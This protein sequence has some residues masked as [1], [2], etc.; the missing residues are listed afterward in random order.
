VIG[1]NESLSS[2][3]YRELVPSFRGQT[4]ADFNRAD[5]NIVRAAVA[6]LPCRR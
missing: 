6:K 1:H 4:H 3:Y 5:M 2:P